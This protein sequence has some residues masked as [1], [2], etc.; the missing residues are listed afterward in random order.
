[1]TSKSEPAGALSFADLVDLELSL[2]EDADAPREVLDADAAL[3]RQEALPEDRRALLRL[4]LNKTRARREHGTLGS[5]LERGYRAASLLIVALL[6]ALGWGAGAG[7]FRYTG[8][9]P[10]N[11]LTIL[12]LLVGGQLAVVAATLVSLVVL[13][14]SPRAYEGI[15]LLDMARAAF[16]GLGGQLSRLFAA[17]SP[18]RAAE[19]R[20]VIAYARSRQTLYGGVERILVFRALQLGGIGF[21]LGALGCLLVTVSV[22]DVAFSWATTLNWTPE[23][24]LRVLSTAAAPWSWAWPAACPDAA[25]IEATQYSR[26]EAAYQGAALGRRG[27]ELAGGWWPFLT[28]SI[29]A[30]ALLPR[31]L[32][33]AGARVSL[34]RTLAA[35]RLDTPE[36]D[37][38]IR[39]LRGP[40]VARSRP[41]DPADVRPLGEDSPPIEAPTKEAQASQAVCV[42]WRD[43]RFRVGDLDSLLRDTF[44]VSREG[45]VGNAGGYDYADD[46]AF[47]ERVR[48]VDD[49]HTPVFV[50]AE[51]WV[52]PDRAFKRFLM[53]LRESAGQTR[54]IN[55]LLTAGGPHAD[56]EMWAGYLAELTDPYLALDPDAAV[57][58]ENT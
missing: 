57:M 17:R 51:P 39:R 47:F 14:V 44:E 16:R 43:A 23:G 2:K 25:L 41:E 22:S 4:W 27:G 38:L 42:R 56:R 26:L 12:V 55:V 21:N 19:L 6:F 18:E 29:A 31:V 5:S 34:A 15:P 35:A 45:P 54:H 52:S 9:H 8:D 11:V 48:G 37:K 24:L 28:M 10:V 3:V 30:Y 49:P 20:R 13:R 40:V 50:V 1:M 33:Y 36:I 53:A 46:E 32:L 58:G 7:L